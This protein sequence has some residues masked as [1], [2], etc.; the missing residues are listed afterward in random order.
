MAK[1]NAVTTIEVLDNGNILF[2]VAGAGSIGFDP[3]KAS[4]E[5]A[6]EALL[7]G[8]KTRIGN[9][10]RMERDEAGNPASPS[11]KFEA[12]KALVDHYESGVDRWTIRV[13]GDGSTAVSGLTL[14]AIANCRFN[15]DIVKAG[16][17]ADAM[18]GKLGI[19]RKALLAQLA[20]AKDVAREIASLKAAK[21]KVNADDLLDE[22]C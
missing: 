4:D 14:Q 8:W 5:C 17:K 19:E 7:L 2:D 12:I 6:R 10:A 15:G 22:L 18:A 3:D 20:N 1:A 13:A 21:S 16:E 11:A 9:A